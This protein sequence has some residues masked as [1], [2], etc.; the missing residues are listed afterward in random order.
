MPDKDSHATDDE[1]LNAAL[2]IPKDED[3][4]LEDLEMI[5]E[6]VDEE[7]TPIDVGDLSAAGMDPAERST[8]KITAFGV[9]KPH[10]DHWQRTPNIT[11]KGAI[12]V[13][14]F[15]TKLRLDAVDHLDTQVNEW[16]DAHPEYEVKFVT[17]T[18]GTLFGKNKEEAMFMNIWV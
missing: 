17:T 1:L 14:T 6:V 7:L 10:E 12:H 5:N 13:K 16:L 9:R 18:I 4:D 11:G 8:S 3:E 15:I 2:P